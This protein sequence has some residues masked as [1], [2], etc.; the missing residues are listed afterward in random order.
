MIFHPW[1]ELREKPEIGVS[2]DHLPEGIAAF[3]DGQHVWMT[4]GMQQTERRCVITHELVHISM[5]HDR[6]QT[7][8][9]EIVVRVETA[10]KLI[11]LTA[12]AAALRWSRHPSEIADELWVTE[13]VLTDR[14]DYLTTAELSVLN[15]INEDSHA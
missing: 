9:A 11:S 2:F 6:C 3:T 12:L 7:T 8:A 15:Q 4:K 1:R 5:G 13:E 10:R 14:L